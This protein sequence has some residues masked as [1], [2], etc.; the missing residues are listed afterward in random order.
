[1]MKALT[2]RLPRC[3]WGQVFAPAR[4]PSFAAKK[5][6]ADMFAMPSSSAARSG[7]G[8]GNGCGGSTIPLL[9]RNAL[10]APRPWEKP[11]ALAQHMHSLD[12]R[13][14]HEHG[15]RRNGT[16]EHQEQRQH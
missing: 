3:F 6:M 11:A 12:E 13:Q 2:N 1:M 4:E 8:N 15:E 9:F 10:P 7:N 16:P 14:Q 5:F